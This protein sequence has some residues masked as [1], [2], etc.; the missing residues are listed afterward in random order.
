MNLLMLLRQLVAKPVASSLCWR[1]RSNR[2]ESIGVSLHRVLGNLMYVSLSGSLSDHVLGVHVPPSPSLASC[3]LLHPVCVFSL[4]FMDGLEHL[5]IA[6]DVAAVVYDIEAILG[7]AD[8]LA[9]GDDSGCC[10]IVNTLGFVLAE[11]LGEGDVDLPAITKVV[12][13]EEGIGDGHDIFWFCLLL[14]FHHVVECIVERVPIAGALFFCA[15]RNHN[16]SKVL[17]LV[18][19]TLVGLQ[20]GSLGLFDG[21]GVE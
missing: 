12:A 13:V 21:D 15:F 4:A 18:S 6:G 19:S 20:G 10:F 3:P 16:V 14:N 11:L 17:V 8:G 9:R 2:F 7:D 1:I 5:D